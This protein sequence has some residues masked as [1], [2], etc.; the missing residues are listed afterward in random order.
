MGEEQLARQRIKAEELMQAQEKTYWRNFYALDTE[1]TGFTKNQPIQIALARFEDGVVAESYNQYIFPTC[2]IEKSG[3]DTHGLT[4]E[5]LRKRGAVQWT[6][7]ESEKLVAFLSKFPDLP[8]VAH[9]EA[10]DHW[11]VLAPAFERVGN[12]RALPKKDRWRCTLKLAK[13]KLI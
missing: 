1:T 12:L 2:K 3:I 4:K 9:N 10:Y 5:E 8:I 11:R 13:R 6:K 7:A